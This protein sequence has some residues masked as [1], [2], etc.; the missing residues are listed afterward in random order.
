M[1]HNINSIIITF[2]SGDERWQIINYK[3]K[4]VL[5]TIFYEAPCMPNKRKHKIKKIYNASCKILYCSRIMNN[6]YPI[7]CVGIFTS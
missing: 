1:T 3:R 6:D 4:T 2:T 5:D 7:I